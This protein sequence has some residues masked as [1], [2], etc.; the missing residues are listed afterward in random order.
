MQC[1]MVNCLFDTLWPKA[2]EAWYKLCMKIDHNYTLFLT[3][4]DGHWPAFLSLEER[5][6][7]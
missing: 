6:G 4:R 3:T 1:P 2:G 5:V 7:E